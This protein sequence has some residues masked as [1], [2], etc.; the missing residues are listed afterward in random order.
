MPLQIL[1]DWP[2]GSGTIGRDGGD[3]FSA[4]VWGDPNPETDNADDPRVVSL[5]AM[6][7]FVL[8]SELNNVLTTI[9]RE[10]LAAGFWHFTAKYVS[11][12][13]CRQTGDA[14]FSYSVGGGTQHITHAKATVGTYVATG[15]PPNFMGAI[16]VTQNGVEGVDI[17][18]KASAFEVTF[19]IAPNNMT[20]AY[21][22]M[23][24]E[25]QEHVNSDQ[26]TLNID[27]I[28]RIYQPGELLYD[29][30]TGSKRKGQGD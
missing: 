6:Q 10:R 14:S 4:I 7:H 30:G 28:Q 16:N 24:E 22:Q 9:A 12:T 21:D 27:G 29:Q 3:E 11:A 13:E 2:S 23:V 20:A 15:T 1:E 17:G 25:L 26:V 19:Y 18:A 5:F 8:I